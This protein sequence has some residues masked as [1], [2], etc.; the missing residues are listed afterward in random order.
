LNEYILADLLPIAFDQRR[1]LPVSVL[2]FQE[3]Q[4]VFAGEMA[5]CQEELDQRNSPAALLKAP[6]LEDT[7]FIVLRGDVASSDGDFAQ[8]GLRKI[9]S[10]QTP[11]E[12]TKM[13]RYGD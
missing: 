13:L 8:A 9:S 12:L 10:E 2:N 6:L 7:F 11:F 5:L 3:F 1:N 4:K